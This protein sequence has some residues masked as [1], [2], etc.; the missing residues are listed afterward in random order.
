MN[1][2]IFEIINENLSKA[3]R[4]RRRITQMT[5][6]ELIEKVVTR[7]ITLFDWHRKVVWDKKM[8]SRYVFDL[9]LHPISINLRPFIIISDGEDNKL[10]DGNNRLSSLLYY[11]YS[12]EEVQEMIKKV[13]TDIDTDN[14][15]LLNTYMKD[16]EPLELSLSESDYNFELSDEEKS[17]IDSFNGTMF[18]DLPD[19]L[20]KYIFNFNVLISK[21]DC[22]T[23]E[24][25]E[26]GRNIYLE[27]NSGK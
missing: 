5:I 8:Q 15:K 1:K 4:N 26:K 3:Q 6:K 27:A 12:S 22:S 21:V 7:E 17:L 18:C 14:I 16:I 13:Y 20:K 2:D 10:V 24:L 9:F 25:L 19:K 23:E 11:L